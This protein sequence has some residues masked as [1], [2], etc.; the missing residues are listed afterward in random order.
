MLLMWKYN[1]TAISSLVATDSSGEVAALLPQALINT[2]RYAAYYKHI[3]AG[4][5]E[6]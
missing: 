2:V 4:V 5:V 3:R 6:G 1:L